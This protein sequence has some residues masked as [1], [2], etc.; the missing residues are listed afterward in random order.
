M[1]HTLL[2]V[3]QPLNIAAPAPGPAKTIITEA[4]EVKFT[5]TEILSHPRPGRRLQL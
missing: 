1:D 5:V 2:F 3:R 4:G